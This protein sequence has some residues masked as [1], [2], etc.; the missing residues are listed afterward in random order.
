MTSTQLSIQ[1]H[2][3][4]RNRAVVTLQALSV[5]AVTANL[6]VEDL[7]ESGLQERDATGSTFLVIP[8]LILIPILPLLAYRAASH[9]LP[10]LG[11]TQAMN[12][13]IAM[14]TLRKDR[15]TQ[16]GA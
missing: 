1:A 4:W 12:S 8:L 10:P 6:W 7:R 11:G 2:T 16:E 15:Q 3:V 13:G 5:E 9:P 14:V